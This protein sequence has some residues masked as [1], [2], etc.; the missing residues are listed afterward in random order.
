MQQSSVNSVNLCS[1][2]L[3]IKAVFKV[4]ELAIGVGVKVIL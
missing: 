3:N 1:E 2:L 4:P